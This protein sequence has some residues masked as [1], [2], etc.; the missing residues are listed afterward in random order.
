[1]IVATIEKA[2]MLVNTMLEDDSLSN[3]ACIVVD[4]LHMVGDPDRGYLL[5]L[6]LTKLRYATAPAKDMDNPLVDGLQI[7]GM[8]ATM[9][10][11]PALA[12]WLNSQ[13]FETDYRPIPLHQ[14]LKKGATL[15][16][17]NVKPVRELVVR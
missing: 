14:Y 13:L 9:P 12:S 1:M 3:L 2:N 16:D 17:E 5:E 10:N 11:M 4:E 6:M 7:I 8:S 15:Y